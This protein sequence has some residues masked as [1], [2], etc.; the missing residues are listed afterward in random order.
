MNY[1]IG[2]IGTGSFGIALASV[3]MDNGHTITLC[4][5]SKTTQEARN[6][7][8]RY[9]CMEDCTIYDTIHF[10]TELKEVCAE[11]DLIILATASKYIPE[12]GEK[13]KPHI[14]ENQKILNVSKGFC[15]ETLQ[16]MS[17]IL[18]EQLPTAD[19]SV[20]SGPTHAEEIILRIPTTCVIGSSTKKTAYFIQHLFMNHYFRVYPTPDIIGVE[21]GGAV[22]NVIALAAGILDGLNYGD[23]T[24][25]ALITRGNVE[26][27]RLGI[28]MGGTAQT[29]SGLAGM[30]DL[31]VTA[32]SNHS[33][34]RNAGYLIGCG[35]SV[36]EACEQVNATVEGILATKN[37]YL[38][39]K[40]QK[41]TLPIIEELYAI[42]YLGKD[43]QQAVSN[44]LNREK[45]HEF[46]S[47]KWN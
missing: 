25:A 43:A 30:G 24:K 23:N 5:M 8:E 4:S 44:L 1:R 21:I 34:N 13:I 16:T 9:T 18:N 42:L 45:C 14:K 33:R 27:A 31:I 3:L 15:T 17:Q 47:L 32:M 38:L 11:K 20:L 22:K 35:Y 37:T 26:I 6:A 7:F 29:F 39:A 19:I 41:V 12:V 2:I 40:K 10:T 36:E 46:K 28:S